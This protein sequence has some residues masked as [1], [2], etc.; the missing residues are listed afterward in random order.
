MMI[1]KTAYF[2]KFGD[3]LCVHPGQ[4]DFGE[5]GWFVSI[6]TNDPRRDNP[7]HPVM[8]YATE[9]GALAGVWGVAQMKSFKA[10]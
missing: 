10:E 7:I 4:N 3:Q 8:W 2:N 6:A 9:A 1:Q 5:H